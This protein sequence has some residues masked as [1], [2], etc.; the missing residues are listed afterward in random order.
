LR[1]F[2]SRRFFKATLTLDFL[3]TRVPASAHLSLH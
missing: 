3:S 1:R 2:S